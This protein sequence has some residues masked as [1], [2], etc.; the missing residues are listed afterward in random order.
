MSIVIPDLKFYF[1]KQEVWILTVIPDFVVTFNKLIVY[2]LIHLPA[3][4]AVIH[5]CVLTIDKTFEVKNLNETIIG[6]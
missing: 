2:F 1:Y 5:R 6:R 4:L 3:T